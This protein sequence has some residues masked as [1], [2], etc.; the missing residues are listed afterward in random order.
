[1]KRLWASLFLVIAFTLGITT[2]ANAG[3]RGTTTIIYN[4]GQQTFLRVFYSMDENRVGYCPC[5]SLFRGQRASHGD[6]DGFFLGP[7]KRA[8]VTHGVS[9]KNIYHYSNS[10]YSNIKSI[11][12]RTGEYVT[13]TTR[14]Y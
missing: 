9:R 3:S 4:G 2:P 14:N 6:A 1:M 8:T 5:V 12:I 11:K 13:V 7:R 10:S